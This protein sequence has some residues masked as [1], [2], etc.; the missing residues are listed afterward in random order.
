MKKNH[1][2]LSICLVALALVLGISLVTAGAW[3][4]PASSAQHDETGPAPAPPAGNERSSAPIAPALNANER[5]AAAPSVDEMEAALTVSLAGPANLVLPSAAFTSDGDYPDGFFMSFSEGYFYGT[6]ASGACLLAPVQLPAGVTITGLEVRLNDN[7]AT[8]V[9]W[10]D[11]YRTNL[12]TGATQ[13]IASVSSP[14]GT[15]GGVVALVDN[16]V[17]NPT[18]SD[19]YAYQLCTCARETVYVYGARIGY[20]HTVALPILH[21]DWSP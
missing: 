15:T 10:F 6:V 16:T 19:M 4:K 18:V 3:A 9:E 8:A 20:S 13:L 1:L 12:A 5:A 2:I 21:R 11:L 7:N 17:L 14:A